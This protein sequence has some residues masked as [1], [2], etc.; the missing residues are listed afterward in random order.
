M[1]GFMAF[2]ARSADEGHSPFTKPGGGTRVGEKLLG[3][4]TLR[5][6]PWDPLLPS[7]P[8]DRQGMPRPPIAFVENGVVKKLGNSRYWAKKMKRQADANYE[9]LIPTGPKPQTLAELVAGLER[10]LVVTRFWYIRMLDPQLV[11]VTGLTRDGVFLVDKGQ[12][13]GPVN[14]FRFNQ[15]V[16]HMFANADGYTAP[17]R[18]PEGVAPA[19]RCKAFHMASKS[20]AV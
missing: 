20:D 4:L 10:G 11:T 1:V 18:T 14:N 7:A 5:A 8:F 15:S 19:L 3:E 16:L 2:D 6:D 17:L 13:V 9:A 12:V